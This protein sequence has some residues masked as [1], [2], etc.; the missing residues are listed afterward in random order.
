MLSRENWN[1]TN[2][3]FLTTYHSPF[4]VFWWV[5][6]WSWGQDLRTQHSWYI[7]VL[8][9]YELWNIYIPDWSWYG[10]FFSPLY[11][12]GTYWYWVLNLKLS[13]KSGTHIRSKAHLCLASG[14][15]KNL[16]PIGTGGIKH[17]S[18]PGTASGPIPCWYWY[19]ADTASG[20]TW[21]VCFSNTS[22]TSTICDSTFAAWTQIILF[23]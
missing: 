10:V 18:V 12:A 4:M 1:P 21:L 22:N 6:G 3:V 20:H 2:C 23:V 11:L 5:V 17:S 14:S 8:V 19:K 9:C 16:V 7:S 13:Y 15:L